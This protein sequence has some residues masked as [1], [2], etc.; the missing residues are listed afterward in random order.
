MKIVLLVSPFLAAIA[1]IAY[2]EGWFNPFAAWNALPVAI[3][4]GVLVSALHS[5]L[6]YVVGC[7][8]FAVVATLLVVL[9]HLA[10]L[11]DWGGTAT[12]SSTSALAF[13][14]VPLWA[15]IVAGA[16]GTLAWGAGML[17]TRLKFPK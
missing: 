11:F 13:I 5:R 1:F 3:G 12:S 9:F 14:F 7:A 2:V 17:V 6:A 8:V 4:C 15:Y 16:T 10:W